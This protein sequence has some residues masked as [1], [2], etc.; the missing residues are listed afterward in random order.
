M[1]TSNYSYLVNIISEDKFIGE[2]IR[3]DCPIMKLTA[4][5]KIKIM[6][7]TENM[8]IDNVHFTIKFLG[9]NNDLV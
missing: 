6:P 5:T 2:T 8:Q 1:T 4:G 7:I 3:F 9:N